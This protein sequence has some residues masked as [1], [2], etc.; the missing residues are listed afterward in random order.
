[1]E[2]L[3]RTFMAQEEEAEEEVDLAETKKEI[4]EEVITVPNDL[5]FWLI[6]NFFTFLT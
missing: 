3:K 2:I 1:M 4:P 6:I 5:N